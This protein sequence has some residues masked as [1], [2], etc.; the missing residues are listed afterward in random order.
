MKLQDRSSSIS[1]RNSAPQFCHLNQSCQ[2]TSFWST[3][4]WI[5]S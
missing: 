2:T 3:D 5:H 4:C 1:D